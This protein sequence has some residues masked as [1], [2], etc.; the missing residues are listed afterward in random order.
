MNHVTADRGAN[1]ANIKAPSSVLIK[2]HKQMGRTH[3]DA[4]S[5]AS[6]ANRRTEG[7]Y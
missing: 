6:L 1:A 2:G 7:Y 3:V 4:F 5:N